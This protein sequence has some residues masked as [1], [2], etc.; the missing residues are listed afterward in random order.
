MFCKAGLC[1]W[2]LW[3]SF[4]LP[5]LLLSVTTEE[6]T[7][8]YG[9]LNSSVSLSLEK[10]SLL[11]SSDIIWKKEDSLMVKFQNFTPIF[12]EDYGTRVKIF[13][14][15][16]LSLAKTLKTDEGK[17]TVLLLDRSGNVTHEEQYFLFITENKEVH[18]VYIIL[19]SSVFLHAGNENAQSTPDIRWKK[20]DTL[21]VRVKNDVPRFYDDYRYRAEIFTNGTL[22]LDST[23]ERDSGI[24][25]VERFDRHGKLLSTE[26][27]HLITIKNA[28]FQKVYGV[29]GKSVFLHVSNKNL[30][31]GIDILW[32]RGTVPVARLKESTVFYYGDYENKA[33]IFTNGTLRLDRI[34]DADSGPYSVVVSDANGRNIH[35][36]IAQLLMMT[37]PGIETGSMYTAGV[38]YGIFRHFVTSILVLIFFVGALRCV[39]K[40]L[41]LH[42][43]KEKEVPIQPKQD[44][45][46]EVLSTTEF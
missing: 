2:L 7:H 31:N 13:P 5:F 6:V 26:A 36:E 12:Y 32:K 8:V 18:P 23:R 43:G 35:S 17:Y 41:H 42:I 22:R 19:G 24:Y 15:G 28:D 10:T 30:L 33:N 37:S 38:I 11:H 4:L 20:G 34:D 21:V 29:L 46:T 14:D 9:A 3:S 45:E 16:T 40:K 25:I 39:I 44:T 1:H 27:H